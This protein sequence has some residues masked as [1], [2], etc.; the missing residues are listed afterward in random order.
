MA[1]ENTNVPVEPKVSDA[2]PVTEAITVNSESFQDTVKKLMASANVKSIRGLKVRNVNIVE[3][4]NYVSVRLTVDKPVPAYM[5]ED[6]GVTYK[7]SL[8]TTVYT[9]T[10]GLAGIIKNDENLAWLANYAV[11]APNV[12]GLVLSGATIDILQQEVAEG[13]SYHNPFTTKTE[14]ED[15]VFSYTTIINHIV[16]I[17]L[18]KVGQK[19]ADKL[20]DKVM[21]S[22]IESAI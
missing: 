12:L 9:T 3:Q 8:I 10:F 18:S 15:T 13:E 19:Y 1:K 4:D 14:V 5:S 11:K 6:G 2:A 21:D 7:K 16:K 17:E 20:A 22:A